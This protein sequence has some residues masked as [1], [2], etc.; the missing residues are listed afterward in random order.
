MNRSVIEALK[1]RILDVKS[2]HEW[3]FYTGEAYT[4]PELAQVVLRVRVLEALIAEH[5]A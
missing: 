4:D 3:A 1:Q 2:S 5:T